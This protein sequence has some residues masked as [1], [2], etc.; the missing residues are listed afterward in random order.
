MTYRYGLSECIEK[1][2]NGVNILCRLCQEQ[3]RTSIEATIPSSTAIPRLPV[4]VVPT[5][6]FSGFAASSLVSSVAVTK[7]V[8]DSKGFGRVEEAA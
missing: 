7:Y 6:N 5:P 1:L 8:C 4:P 3:K 2:D